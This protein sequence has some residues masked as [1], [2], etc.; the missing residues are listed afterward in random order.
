MAVYKELTKTQ[1]SLMVG[2]TY[3][4]WRDGST[5]AE[6][7]ECLKRPIEEVNEWVEICKIAF[8]K[9]TP[10]EDEKVR[11]IMRKERVP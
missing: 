11:A 6:I 8:T 2:R 3:Y 10:E 7:A 4:M 5:N 9:L 1:L